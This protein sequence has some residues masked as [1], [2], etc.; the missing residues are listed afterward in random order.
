MKLFVQNPK[1]LWIEVFLL[2]YVANVINSAFHIRE[3]N[4]VIN[5]LCE[6]LNSFSHPD[7]VR[8]SI[9][10]AQQ[11]SAYSQE[12][13]NVLK[14]Y[15]TIR[16]YES[17]YITPMEYGQ[18]DSQN[19]LAAKDHYN[20]LLMKRNYLIQD[21]KYALNPLRTFKSIFFFPNSLIKWIGFKPKLMTSKLLS[22]CCWLLVYFLDLYSD[23]IK[24]LTLLLFQYLFH[25]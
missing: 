24:N 25:A 6:Y 8:T 13:L 18:P 12:L 11:S 21:L 5:L 16:K 15:P 1:E 10:F 3:I 17:I 20:Y 4:T 22:L 23:E 2:F 19:Y 9:T 14:S 7:F